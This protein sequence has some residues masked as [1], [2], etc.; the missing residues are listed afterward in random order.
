[1]M[2]MIFLLAALLIVGLLIY[3]QLDTP[4]PDG[5][6]DMD[7][8]RGEMQVPRVPTNPEDLPSFEQDINEFMEESAAQ[9]L[10]QMEQDTQ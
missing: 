5:D 3:R 1:M 9:R 4:A 6:S 10:N 2:R 8:G 7:E